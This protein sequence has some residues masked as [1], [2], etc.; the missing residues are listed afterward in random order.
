MLPSLRTL[1]VLRRKKK[2]EV[3]RNSLLMYISPLLFYVFLLR[4]SIIYVHLFALFMVNLI[5]LDH[6]GTSMQTERRIL[7]NDRQ[8]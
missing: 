2:E 7:I 1:Q 5:V 3:T 6:T 4:C 8:D